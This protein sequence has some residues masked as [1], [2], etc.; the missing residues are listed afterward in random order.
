MADVNVITLTGRLTKDWEL[1]ETS[2][3]KK[4]LKLSMASNRTIT[5]KD[6]KWETVYESKPLFID[7]LVFNSV[8][9]LAK[10]AQ[11]GKPLTVQGVL[12]TKNWETKEGQ[13]RISF[14]ILADTV[15]FTNT[16]KSEESAD[17]EPTWDENLPF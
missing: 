10:S 1:I 3:N 13:K 16:T 2:N 14:S 5:R 9:Y 12:D 17:A 4:F 11:K 6:E 8:D 15:V 7:V